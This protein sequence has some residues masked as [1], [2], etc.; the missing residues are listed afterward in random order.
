MLVVGLAWFGAAEP[1][2]PAAAEVE[3]LV[4]GAF[5]VCGCG[6]HL[7]GGPHAPVCFGCSVGKA[8]LAFIQEGLAAGRTP[9]E[10]LLELADPILVE[11][12]ADYGAARLHAI[13][14]RA[15]RVAGELGHR[16]VVLRTQAR[17]A[18]ALRAVALAE[19][20]RLEGSFGSM[21][22]ALIRHGG[23]WDED[24]LLRLAERE[25]LF[26]DS[27]RSCLAFVDVQS[28]IDK[29]REHARDRDVG[30]RPAWFVNREPVD[31]SDAALRRAIESVI[32]GES[33]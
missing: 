14:E 25:G 22:R 33:I 3:R 10:I 24:A 1:T 32:R 27:M 30:D 15:R 8:D 18:G 5:C 9:K 17:S 29:D 26:L 12:F 28:Q 31:D 13:W 2:D 4:A 16:R 6:N 23:P 20:A 7:P 21:Q 11:V 19:C